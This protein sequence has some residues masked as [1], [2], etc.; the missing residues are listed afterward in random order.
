[1]AKRSRGRP[2]VVLMIDTCV[3]LELAKDY[4]QRSLL[5][6][7][8]ELIRMGQ[9]SLLTP[10]LVIEEFG[11][12]KE[13]IVEE[14]GRSIGSTLRRAK[15]MLTKL[16]EEKAKAEAIKQLNEI[17]QQSVNYR[18]AA[19]E[20]VK[21]IEA[22]FE[23]STQVRTSPDI[24]LAAADRA[25]KNKAPFH[26]QRNSMND[27]MLIEIFGY[28]QKGRGGHYVFV[29][30]NIK[31]FS[32]MGVDEQ[33]PHPDIAKFFS[34]KSHY[35]T[36]LGDALNK[37]RPDEF[38]D[39]MVE[40]SWFEPPR[41]YV[42]IVEAIEKMR[43]QVWYNRHQVWNEKL[44]SGQAILIGDDEE[45]GKD[46]VGLRIHRR[47]WEAAEKSAGRVEAKYGLTELGPWTDFEWGMINGKLSALRWVLGDDWDMLDT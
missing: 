20:G 44:E 22:L 23:R 27:A 37:F 4:S 32:H 40:Q 38:N 9:V 5:S 46:P 8:E 19:S 25:I 28:M 45:R 35:F 39:I 6:A 7:L 43:E 2:S 13:R 42:D 15:E 12:N 3:W 17:D 18:D 21:R 30:H 41:R 11:R 31:D 10:Q 29:T 34:T 14:S 16:G 33:K 47:I 1:M 24:K 36:K 26:R